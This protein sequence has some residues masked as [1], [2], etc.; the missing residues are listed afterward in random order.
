MVSVHEDNNKYK[1]LDDSILVEIERSEN[2]NMDK[3]KSLILSLK[4]KEF[5]TKIWESEEDFSKNVI[6]CLRLNCEN[7][8]VAAIKEVG[9][10]VPKN[11]PLYD[12][13]GKVSTKTS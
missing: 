11:V 2:E 1:H 6:H 7:H 3:A 5:W 9:L 10:E 4:K 8:F 13:S 12:N